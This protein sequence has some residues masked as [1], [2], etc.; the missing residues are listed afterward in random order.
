MAEK[1]SFR[2]MIPTNMQSGIN[3]SSAHLYSCRSVQVHQQLWALEVPE[4]RR[5]TVGKEDE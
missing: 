2:N 3:I 1:G 4:V 5:K